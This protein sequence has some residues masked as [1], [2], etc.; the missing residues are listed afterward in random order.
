MPAGLTQSVKI[1][2]AYNLFALNGPASTYDSSEKMLAT[3]TQMGDQIQA[4]KLTS[5]WF[6]WVAYYQ[7]SSG[8]PQIPGQD[9][10]QLSPLS[11]TRA[12]KSKA[13]GFAKVVYNVVANF[14]QAFPKATPEQLIENIVGFYLPTD[15]KT[16]QTRAQLTEQVKSLLRGVPDYTKTPDDKSWYPDPSQDDSAKYNLDPFVWFAHIKLGMT[17][18]GFSID[19]DTADVGVNG[20]ENLYVSIGS[21]AGLPNQDPYDRG[22]QPG[23]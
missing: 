3:G 11:I 17:G 19:D 18:Y 23:P 4:Q 16:T 1:P 6:S 13:D 8:A 9:Q 2:G 5:L 20:A 22:P 21:L 7:K 10:V 12:E 15:R 14:R